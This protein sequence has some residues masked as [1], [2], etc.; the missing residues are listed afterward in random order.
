MAPGVRLGVHRKEPVVHLM[1]KAKVKQGLLHLALEAALDRKALDAVVL[2]LS[3]ISSFTDHFIIC[4][5][6]STRQNQAISDAIQERLR[7]EG[8]RPLHV[9]GYREGEWI[10]MDYVHFVVHIFLAKSREYYDLER[11]WRSGKR[12]NAEEFLKSA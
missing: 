12:Q 6:T 10:L 8:T 3:G 4:N 5:G 1:P 7:G 2:D 11:L 9:E